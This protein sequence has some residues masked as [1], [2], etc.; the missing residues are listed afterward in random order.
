MKK[1]LCAVLAAALFLLSLLP[2]AHAADVYLID[3][4]GLLDEA[5]N[6]S[7][8]EKLSEVSGSIGMD[9]L[10]YTTN[11]LSGKSVSAYADDAM[12]YEFGQ[13]DDGIMLLISMED[14]DYYVSTKEQGLVEFSEGEFDYIV[15]A[16]LPDLSDGNYAAA[17]TAFA[18]KVGSVYHDPSQ[19]PDSYEYGQHTQEDLE[20]SKSRFHFSFLGLLVSFVFGLIVALIVVGGMKRQLKSARF[21][22]AN[23]Y[24]VPGSL[25]LVQNTDLFLYSNVT[26]T[27]IESESSSGGG[28]GV[29]TS[30]SGSSHGGHGGK[31]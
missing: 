5:E 27:R 24:L 11:T 22:N 17:F 12:D 13:V 29:H 3:N 1:T 18:E 23:T 26:R 21:H 20:R 10:I 19:V 14:R 16:F 6:A 4:A 30:S 25:N 8:A 28:G 9:V 15:A 31:F 2:A 7:V